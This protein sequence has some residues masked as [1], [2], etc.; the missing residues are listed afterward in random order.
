M[1]KIKDNFGQSFTTIGLNRV[2]YFGLAPVFGIVKE[3]CG[4][5]WINSELGQGLMFS[6]FFHVLR[7]LRKKTVQKPDNTKLYKFFIFNLLRIPGMF[8]CAFP[9]TLSK[10]PHWFLP[11]YL[12]YLLKRPMN[13]SRQYGEYSFQTIS[14]G[15]GCMGIEVIVNCK[16]RKLDKENKRGKIIFSGFANILCPL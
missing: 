6:F 16:A 2:K 11:G 1:E 5:Y 15:T 4:Y 7:N 8:W 10:T 14:E 3:V 9:D 12:F 13:V